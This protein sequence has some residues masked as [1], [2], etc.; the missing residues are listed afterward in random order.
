MNWQYLLTQVLYETLRSTDALRLFTRR[1]RLRHKCLRLDKVD[2]DTES[3]S[4]VW[5]THVYTNT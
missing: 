1:H 4:L 2:E 5:T 3:W